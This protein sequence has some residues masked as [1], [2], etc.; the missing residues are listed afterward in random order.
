M[1]NQ[2][3]KKGLGIVFVNAGILL[4]IILVHLF[5]SFDDGCSQLC[6]QLNGCCCI[7]RLLSECVLCLQLCIFPILETAQNMFKSGHNGA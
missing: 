2:K 3:P 7:L 4:I 1:Y 5:I 6:S